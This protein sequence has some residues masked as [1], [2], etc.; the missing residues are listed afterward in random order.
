MNSTSISE[1]APICH[2]SFAYAGGGARAGVCEGRGAVSGA[3]VCVVREEDAHRLEVSW[4]G[5]L[6]FHV[7]LEERC[8]VSAL[9]AGT[10]S[11]VMNGEVPDMAAHVISR[12]GELY[13]ACIAASCINIEVG[14]EWTDAAAEEALGLRCDGEVCFVSLGA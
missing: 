5:Q 4:G 13:D 7:E 9:R 3:E 8:I 10:L 14:A 6:Q 2:S 11:L 12:G 1:D